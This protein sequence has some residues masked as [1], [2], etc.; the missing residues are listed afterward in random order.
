[1]PGHL[2]GRLVQGLPIGEQCVGFVS[3]SDA[4]A[5]PAAQVGRSRLQ[6]RHDILVGCLDFGLTGALGQT[7][8]QEQVALE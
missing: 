3:F 5:C 4:A 2:G 8:T 7:E 1:M 6:E